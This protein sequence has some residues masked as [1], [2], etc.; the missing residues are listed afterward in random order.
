MAISRVATRVG[1]GGHDIPEK[2]IRRR[3]TTGWK[4]FN[5]IYKNIVNEWAL[6]DNSGKAPELLDTGENK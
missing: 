4:N 1:Q 5:N 6:Y 2:V 3:F